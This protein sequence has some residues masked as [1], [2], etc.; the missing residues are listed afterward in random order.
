LKGSSADLLANPI[1]ALQPEQDSVDVRLA[2]AHVKLAQLEVEKAVEANKRIAN[3][4]SIE[5][6]ELLKLHVLNDEAELEQSLS[7]EQ[8]DAHEVC[9]KNGEATLR[10]A[11]SM[12]PA[13]QALYQKI[14]NSNTKFAL[15]QALLRVEI[16]ELELEQM[17]EL[18][19]HDMKSVLL[20][21]Q[22]QVDRLR[23]EVTKLQL[24]Q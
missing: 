4:Y 24:R 5:Y 14:P 16:A 3:T 6:V 23:D 10:I 8:M 17:K 21:L 20:H 7:N 18:Q 22:R 1:F 15:D 2:R 11:K 12:L 19:S 13:Y 9:I